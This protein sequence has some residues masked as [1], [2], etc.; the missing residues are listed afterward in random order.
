MFI[1]VL[2]AAAGGAFPQWN[3]SCFNCRRLRQGQFHGTPRSQAQ[4]AV[5]SNHKDWFLL[6][7]SP[8]L[9]Y[10]IESFPPLHPQ[11]SGPSRD[12]PIQ[13]VVLLSAEIDAAMGLLLLR[14]SQPLAV[15]ATAAVR[16][17]LVEDNNM[18][19][20]L[21][22]QVDQVHW[23]TLNPGTPVELC[24]IDHQCSGIT[25]TP[26]S[27]GGGFPG[28]VSNNRAAE[29]P[30][31][32][33]ALGV[34]LSDGAKRVALFPSAAAVSP[35]SLEAMEN[36]D[37]VFFD[38]TFWSDDELIRVQGAGKTAAQMGHLAISG[39]DGTLARFSKLKKPRK[40]FIHINNTN[41]MLDLDS[42]EFRQICDAGWELAV[43]GMELEL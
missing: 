16:K 14:E 40:I 9:R 1:K 12:S 35:E 42:S 20:V 10:Q 38:G 37:A 4:L 5:T 21:R 3:C 28:H 8:D 36:C 30:A 25:C 29:L 26:V 32:E 41:P 2:G 24:G 19:G 31:Q 6:N 13:A 39:K 15:Y 7:A 43:D 18:F 23:R 22:R 34:Y 27:A 17:L 33:A 11:G